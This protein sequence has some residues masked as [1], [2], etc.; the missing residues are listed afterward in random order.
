MASRGQTDGLRFID[1]NFTSTVIE[2]GAA[3]TAV[4]GLI[5]E[6]GA[7]RIAQRPLPTFRL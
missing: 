3:E 1:A 6:G 2:S 4:A 5:R 7:N